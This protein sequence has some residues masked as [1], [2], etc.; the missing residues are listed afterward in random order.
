M[1]KKIEQH[2]TPQ[3]SSGMVSNPCSTSNTR[4]VTVCFIVLRVCSTWFCGICR[5]THSWRPCSTQHV[6]Y[7]ERDKYLLEHTVKFSLLVRCFILVVLSYVVCTVLVFCSWIVSLF[8]NY[9]MTWPLHNRIITDQIFEEKKL[10]RRK[11]SRRCI[12]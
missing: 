12:Y 11:R 8:P 7:M 2:R 6:L 5:D 9:L 4:R 10:I 3:K 1:H